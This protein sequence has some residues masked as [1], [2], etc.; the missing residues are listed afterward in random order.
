M[1]KLSTG[2]DS[3]LGNYLMLTRAVFGRESKAVRFLEQ[4][5]AESPNGEDE[6]VISDE[7]QMIN[8]LA[9]IDIGAV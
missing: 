2:Q 7:A 3:T 9:Q 6:E 5:I 4:K 8:L 1:T